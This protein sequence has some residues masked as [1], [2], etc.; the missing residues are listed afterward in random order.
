MKMLVGRRMFVCD[1]N[2]MAI[3]E[4]KFIKLNTSIKQRDR[5]INNLSF[6]ELCL[7]GI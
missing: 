1:I 3:D 7:L 6:L 2:H 4:V 5:R